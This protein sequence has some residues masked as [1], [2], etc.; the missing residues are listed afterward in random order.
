MNDFYLD[1]IPSGMLLRAIQDKQS[2]ID[3]YGKL[4][5]MASD[6]QDIETINLIL[7]DEKNHLRMF[8]NL[9]QNLYGVIPDIPG[10]EI[11]QISSFIYGI[12]KSVMAELDLF[13]FYNNIYF[14]DTNATVR[15]VFLRALRDEIRHAAK[16]N[17]IYTQ[18]VERR[19]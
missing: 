19:L 13:N 11:S 2:M 18:L 3:Y 8:T 9:Y 16:C 10:S 12:K 5:K 4:Y 17:F 7:L 14:T 1:Q 6:N 15:D